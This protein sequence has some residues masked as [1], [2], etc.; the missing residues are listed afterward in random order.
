MSQDVPQPGPG[1]VRIRVEACGVCHSDVLVKIGGGGWL[2]VDFPRTPGHEIAGHVDAVGSGV[3]SWK[4]GERVGVGWH[5]GHCFTCDPCRRGDFMLCQNQKITGIHYDGGYAEYVVVPAEA[6]ARIPE[7]LSAEEAAPLMCAGITVF[8]AL[9]NSGARAGDLVAVQGIGGLGHLA[10]QYAAKMGFDTVAI[11]RGADKEPLAHQLGARTY[12]DS[13]QSNWTQA[14]QK[15]GGARVALATAP[16]AKSIAALL[17]GLGD[18]GKV[19]MVGAPAEP[20]TFNASALISR[21]QG[22]AAWPSGI[23]TD[24]EDAMRFAVQSGIR[25]M[26]ETFPLAEANEAFEKMMSGKVRFRA[27]LVNS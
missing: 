20:L 21:R 18:S 5:G 25:P 14:L 9:R 22:L 3:A 15:R 27:V 16:D 4:L 8:N 12:I 19:V 7:G 2:P 6:V 1:Q 26:I 10:V 17:G 24:S 23:A 11:G 13:T